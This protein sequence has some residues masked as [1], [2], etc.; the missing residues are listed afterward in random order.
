M[1]YIEAILCLRGAKLPGLFAGA[2]N[3]SKK[4]CDCVAVI[5]YQRKIDFSIQNI[6]GFLK[7]MCKKLTFAKKCVIIKKRKG[8]DFMNIMDLETPLDT[9]KHYAPKTDNMYPFYI[10]EYGTTKKGIPCYQLR[11]DSHIACI[12][13]VISGTGVIIKDDKIYTVN[14]GDT[15]LLTEKSNQIYY[16]NPDNNFE[17]IWINFKG[18]LATELFEIYDINNT[19]VFK[20]VDTYNIL[21]E[22]QE[23]CME[24]KNADVY[25]K[26][27]SELFFKL[28]L[29]LSENK[30][31]EQEII[32]DVEKIRLYIDLRIT[33]NI[34]IEDVAKEFSFSREYIIRL[35]KKTYGITPHKYIL[36]SKMRIAMI[37][38]KTK[39]FSIEEISE[40]LNFSDS[41]H[42]SAQ[43]KK[44]TGYTPSQYRK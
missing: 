3:L 11:L 1:L 22:I 31:N 20:N 17:R 42:F 36:H 18:R 30:S 13:Y 40:K 28:V 29:F 38:L 15:F 9:E 19:V 34:K 35:F 43:F 5:L 7:K 6:D 10:T 2:C 41:H 39:D 8:E 25:K 26:E 44:I 16:S 23:K 33:E 21:K 4:V 14:A 27:T 37:M 24:T 32:N 12:Q